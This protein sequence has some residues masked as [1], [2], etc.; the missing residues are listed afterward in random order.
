M[1]TS[2]HKIHMYITTVEYLCACPGLS[3]SPNWDPAHPLS[4]KRVCPP[5]NQRVGVGVPIRTAEEKPSTLS[6]LCIWMP[7]DIMPNSWMPNHECRNPEPRMRLNAEFANQEWDWMPKGTECRNPLFRIGLNAEIL[8]A[9]LDWM[10]NSWVPKSWM[11]KWTE[12][13]N[14][15]CRIGLNAEFLNAKFL[16]A[17]VPLT[18]ACSTCQR[19]KV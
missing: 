15:E 13:R 8:Y 18:S 12:C 9:E 4:R 14:F 5:R 17:V 16:K 3:P 19:E 6:T 2:V 11:P 1:D 10:P 7:R